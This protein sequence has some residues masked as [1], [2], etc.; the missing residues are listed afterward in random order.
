MKEKDYLHYLV[1]EIH[2]VIVATVDEQGR[3]FTA[4]IDMMDADENSIYFL[5]AKGKSFYN[6]LKN[7]EY[8]ALTGLKGETTMT[9]VSLSL[10]GK[11]REIGPSFLP[12]LFEK[13]PYMNDIYPTQKSR[14]ALTVFQIYE[15]SG[16]WFDL[17]KLPIKRANFTFGG[18][19]QIQD[20]YFVTDACTG[21]K[22]CAAKCPQNCI[23]V[24]KQPAEIVQEHCLRCGNCFECCPAKAII[25]RG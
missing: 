25:K 19:S 9:S 3:P 22:A 4:A 7:G 11:V 17:S 18:A 16:E 12:G 14:S 13:N 2:T 23:D 15:G 6:R 21:C 20:G 24:T 8:I 1:D 5:T 10:Q